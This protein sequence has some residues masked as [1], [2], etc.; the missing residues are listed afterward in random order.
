MNKVK[1]TEVNSINMMEFK[2]QIK[3]LAKSEYH[4]VEVEISEHRADGNLIFN[5]RAYINDF[6]STN[7]NTP[8]E[9]ISAMRKK[10]YPSK[11]VYKE[12]IV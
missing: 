9:A 4:T 5:F 2:N 1:V 3:K 8:K 10:V 12:I 6:G 7:G 11:T